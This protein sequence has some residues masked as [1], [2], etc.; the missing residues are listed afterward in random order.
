MRTQTKQT[1]RQVPTASVR[2]T[3]AARNCQTCGWV[4]VGL[5]VV[6]ALVGTPEFGGD[7]YTEMVSQLASIRTVISSLIATLL[8]VSC[9]VLR[10]LADIVD[11]GEQ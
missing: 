1:F 3:K 8:F 11:R 2:I 6:A 5:V 10:A 4:C 7:A 9:A